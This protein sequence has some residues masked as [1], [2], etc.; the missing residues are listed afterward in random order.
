MEFGLYRVHI[1]HGLMT[2]LTSMAVSAVGYHEAADA[3]NSI[4]TGDYSLNAFRE[5]MCSISNAVGPLQAIIGTDICGI[6][7]MFQYSSMALLILGSFGVL[8]LLIGGFFQL[9]YWTSKAREQ[10]RQWVLICYGVAPMLFF[11]GISQYTFFTS[12][13][14]RFPPEN[15]SSFGNAYI[16]A[17]TFTVLS[18]LPIFITTKFV[19][20]SYKEE[21]N[22]SLSAQKHFLREQEA[23]QMIADMQASYGAAGG[24]AAAEY[25]MAAPEYGMAPVMSGPAQMSF[26]PAPLP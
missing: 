4:T 17:A 24:M 7:V 23:G 21:I 16:C 20:H 25:G 2:G 5:A 12:H 1:Y 19:S 3:F 13:L 26:M 6:F 11:L 15:V 10:K 9:D 18:L 14:S 22:E 8:F